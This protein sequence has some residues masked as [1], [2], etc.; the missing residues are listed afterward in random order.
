MATAQQCVVWKPNAAEFH[1]LYR[2]I[3]SAGIFLEF[4]DQSPNKPIFQLTKG[5]AVLFKMKE[6]QLKIV[7]ADGALPNVLDAI[8]L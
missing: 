2:K 6:L 8:K 5:V 4:L 7:L 1:E 3:D